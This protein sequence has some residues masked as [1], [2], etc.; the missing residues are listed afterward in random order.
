MNINNFHSDSL[1]VGDI[2]LEMGHEGYGGYQVSI[3]RGTVESK[4]DKGDEVEIGGSL[5]QRRMKPFD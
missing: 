5:G 2:H 1:V 4:G 3:E